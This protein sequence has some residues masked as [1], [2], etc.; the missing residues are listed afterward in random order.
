M[1]SSCYTIGSTHEVRHIPALGDGKHVGKA[2]MSES[3][4]NQYNELGCPT[5]SPW[6]I[7]RHTT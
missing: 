1:T 6:L 2:E 5:N 3:I 7:I 4:F